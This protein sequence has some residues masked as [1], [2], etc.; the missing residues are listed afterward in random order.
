MSLPHSPNQNHLLAA[1]PPAEFERLAAYLELVPMAV[2][3]ARSRVFART[4]HDAGIGRQHARRASRRH[5][6]GSREATEG[7]LHTLPPRPY[8]GAGSFRAGAG[9]VRMLCRGQEGAA[10]PVVG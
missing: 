5:Y 9:R 1:L 10:T 3:D 8:H 7:R 4:D 6:R 2:A